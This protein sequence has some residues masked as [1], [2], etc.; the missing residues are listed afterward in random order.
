MAP[1]GLRETGEVPQPARRPVLRDPP[2]GVDR[3]A[4][5]LPPRHHHRLSQP[6]GAGLPE[7]HIYRIHLHYCFQTWQGSGD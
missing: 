5:R 4:G 7:A 6:D 1:P 3:A 2:A